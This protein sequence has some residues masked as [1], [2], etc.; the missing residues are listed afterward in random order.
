MRAIDIKACGICIGMWIVMSEALAQESDETADG[1]VAT[2]P[3]HVP[4]IREEKLKLKI[5][6]RNWFIVPIPVSNPTTDTGLVLG[7]A[8]FYPQTEAEKGTQPPSVTGAGGYYSLEQQQMA[9]QRRRCSRRPE[10]GVERP[11]RG[12]D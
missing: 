9:L 4:D 7:G 8:Y 11:R 10:F 6:E 1:R 12:D 3:D 2:A 5:Q